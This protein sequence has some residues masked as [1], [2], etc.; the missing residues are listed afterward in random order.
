MTVELEVLIRPLGTEQQ[1]HRH[2]REKV[3]SKNGDSYNSLSLKRV[4]YSRDNNSH[5]KITEP[6]EI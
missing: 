3:E 5:H 6:E 4:E 2:I 1:D